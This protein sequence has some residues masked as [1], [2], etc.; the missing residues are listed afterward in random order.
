[1]ERND[2]GMDR[3]A[4]LVAGPVL[5]VVGAAGLGGLFDIGLSGTAGLALF[6]VLL[7]VGL[8][9]ITTGV[10]W[11]CPANRIAGVNTCDSE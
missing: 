6:G 4:R 7:I 11:K 10:T 3:T 8:V 5:A 2:G 1:M 9:F